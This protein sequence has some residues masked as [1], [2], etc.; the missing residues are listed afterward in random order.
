M[1]GITTGEVVRSIYGAWRLFL[2]D[3][4]G[5]AHFSTDPDA[6]LRSFWCAP[7]LLPLYWV[8]I[9]LNGAGPSDY[10]TSLFSF[11]LIDMLAYTVGWVAWPV[12]MVYASAAM[13]RERE[14]FRYLTVFNWSSAPLLALFALSAVIQ[15]VDFIPREIGDLFMVAAVIWQFIFHA[16]IV[17]LTLKVSPLAIAAIVGG[18]FMLGQFIMG[19]REFA[20]MV[21]S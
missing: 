1:I 18:E 8:I 7:I 14:Y 17:R 6:A 19:M 15:K 21:P 12:V 11:I 5:L 4:K 13:D 3:G 20:L 2:R 16:F 9:V 10:G